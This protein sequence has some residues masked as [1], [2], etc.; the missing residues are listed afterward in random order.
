MLDV[1]WRA[2]GKIIQTDDF[3]GFQKRFA[4]MR[5]DKTGAASDENVFFA[6]NWGLG[7][8]FL[9]CPWQRFDPCHGQGRKPMTGVY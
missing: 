7:H 6:K 3:A 8:K 5:A 9:R 2:V 4:K 1:D